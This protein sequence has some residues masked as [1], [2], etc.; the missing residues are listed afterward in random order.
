MWTWILKLY[1]T[2]NTILVFV[3]IVKFLTAG[4][5]ARMQAA[6][7]TCSY[8]LLIYQLSMLFIRSLDKLLNIFAPLY[9]L[10]AKGSRLT[11]R[12]ILNL[13]YL[14]AKGE[15]NCLLLLFLRKRY[16][17]QRRENTFAEMLAKDY[18]QADSQLTLLEYFLKQIGMIC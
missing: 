3:K 18:K 8:Y 15:A 6:C 12:E 16:H 11:W 4:R 10:D 13:D 2:E 5:H 1:S 7:K 14:Y 9:Y 17:L